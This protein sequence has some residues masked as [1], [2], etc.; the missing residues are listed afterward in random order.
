MNDFE[1]SIKPLQNLNKIGY[2]IKPNLELNLVHNPID[3]LLPSKKSI[4]EKEYRQELGK[5]FDCTAGHGSY[6]GRSLA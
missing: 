1:K 5:R 6:C 4:L 2:D 3:F